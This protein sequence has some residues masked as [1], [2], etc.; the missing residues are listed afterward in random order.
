MKFEVS[1][2]QPFRKLIVFDLAVIFYMLLSPVFG[3]E[4]KY[5]NPESAKNPA[6]LFCDI[7]NDE[8]AKLFFWNIHGYGIIPF[9]GQFLTLE[10]KAE[11][12]NYKVFQL[13]LRDTRFGL[14]VFANH[15]I[16]MNEQY[17][18]DSLTASVSDDDGE[19]FF[20]ATCYVSK[21]RGIQ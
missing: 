16:S 18:S 15:P 7:S 2:Y 21:E 13:H 4:K 12:R 3:I 19:R 5:Q 8:G 6:R 1:L 17:E 14:R 20:Q 11:V 10:L 9:A